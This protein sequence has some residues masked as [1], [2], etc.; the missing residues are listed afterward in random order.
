MLGFNLWAGGQI[1]LIKPQLYWTN[2][3]RF[4]AISACIT[5]EWTLFVQEDLLLLEMR[6]KVEVEVKAEGKTCQT[7]YV[8]TFSTIIFPS[9]AAVVTTQILFLD[10]PLKDRLV[11][12][13]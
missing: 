1:T 2:K 5:A 7:N 12:V 8:N 6:V 11:F 3:N 9:A 13:S 4:A 10:F